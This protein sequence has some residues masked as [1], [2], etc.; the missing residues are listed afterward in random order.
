MVA[1]FINPEGERIGN[2]PQGVGEAHSTHDIKDSITFIEGRCLTACMPIT[3]R[4]GLYSPFEI[5]W[6]MRT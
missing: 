3:G 4:G 2:A 1:A 6:G 5:Q